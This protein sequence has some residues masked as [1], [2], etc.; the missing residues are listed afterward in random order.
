MGLWKPH[1]VLLCHIIPLRGQRPVFLEFRSSKVFILVAVCWSVFTDVFLYGVVVP[2]IPFALQDRVHIP[3]EHTQHWVSV[4][5]AVYAAALLF[6]APICG[7]V[8]D[9]TSSRKGPLLVGLIVLAGSTLMFCLGQTIPVLVVGRMLQGASASVVWTVALALLADTVGEDESGQA[10]GY[11]S[12]ATSLGILVAPLIGGVVYE[13]SGYYAVFGVTFAVIGL[14]ILLRLVLIEK[15]TAV[16]WLGPDSSSVQP[17][18]TGATQTDIPLPDRDRSAAGGEKSAHAAITE[19]SHRHPKRKLPPMLILLRSRRIL[20]AFWGN[21]VGAMTF[22][23][24]DTTLPLYVNQ[25][26]GWDSLGAG[27]A[28]IALL[29]PSFA[30]PVIGHWTDKYG[31][32]W[33]AASGLFLSVPFWVLLRLVDHDT[34]GQAVLLCALLVLLGLA[35]ALV[36]TSLMAEF[37]KV[38]DAKVRQEPDL[39]A[40]KSAYAQSYGIF[41]V[42]WAAGSLLGPLVSGSIRTAAGWKTMTWTMALWCAVGVLPTVL[43][44]GGMIRKSQRPNRG[45]GVLADETA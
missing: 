11:V 4:L 17:S 2:V 42:A 12:L 32:R 19:P 38:C 21:L 29:A 18:S 15:K 39:F 41:N 25:I 40:G 34:V 45:R 10:I 31:P 24:V 44:S 6:L 7:I 43:Y 3:H 27:L 20:A 30:G 8:A 5:L 36:L 14:D 33:I 1:D 26:F 37:S 9:R 16:R 28:F 13:K 22:T 23:A 35:T